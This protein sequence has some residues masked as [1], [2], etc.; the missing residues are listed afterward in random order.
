MFLALIAHGNS[1]LLGRLNEYWEMPPDLVS[2][3]VVVIYSDKVGF[4]L[5]HKP[6]YRVLLVRNSYVNEDHRRMFEYFWKNGSQ[7]SLSTAE[8]SYD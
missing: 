1:R 2:A 7:P 8:E 5:E 6:H 4:L 3:E